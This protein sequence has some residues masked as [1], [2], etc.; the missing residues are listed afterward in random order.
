MATVRAAAGGDPAATV[1][2]ALAEALFDHA[3]PG[4]AES[5]D[6]AAR[7]AITAFVAATAGTRAPGTP[8]LALDTAPGATGAR[9]RLALAI[10]NDDMPFLVDSVASAITAAGLDID[11]LLHPIVDVRRDPAGGLLAVEGVGHGT[12]IPGTTRESIIYIEFE[13]VSAKARGELLAALG[14]VLADI[15]AAVTDWPAMLDMLRAATRALAENPPPVAPHAAAEATAFLDWLAADNFT[16]L[17]C[18]RYA[19][20]GDLDDPA[21]EPRGE[22]GLGLLRNPDYPLWDGD[23]AATP[24]QLRRVLALPEPL[25]IT[26]AGAVSTVHRRVNCDLVAVKGF[27]HAGRVVS[28]TRFLGLFTSSALATSPRQV[29]LLRRK[30]GEVI[31]ALGFAK[32]GHTGKALVH[33]LE[34]FPREELF[35]ASPQRLKAMALGPV[36][37]ARPAAAQVVRAHRSVRP[38]RLGARLCAARRLH[39]RGPRERRPDAGNVAG[40][41]RVAL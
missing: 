25:L 31:D 40:R 41:D 5:I 39:R 24:P 9:R 15:R 19:L 3:L 13:R 11:R 27:D 36:V 1:E 21:Y 34:G 6:A 28:E 2:A 7:T 14:G 8:A 18:R 4:E 35:E 12:A 33:V 30:V 23:S 16:L 37:A 10:V 22:A 32:G 17:G 29:P 38:L 20:T 26:K